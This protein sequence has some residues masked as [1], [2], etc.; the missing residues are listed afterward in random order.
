M[1]FLRKRPQPPATS[2]PQGGTG[3]PSTSHVAKRPR[4]APTQSLPNI[5]TLLRSIPPE[6][7]DDIPART[8]P[9]RQRMSIRESPQPFPIPVLNSSLSRELPVRGPVVRSIGGSGS[10]NGSGSGSG[11]GSGGGLRSFHSVPTLPISLQQKQRDAN[12]RRKDE[13]MYSLWSRF[14]NRRKHLL[15]LEESR[16]MCEKQLEDA[17]TKNSEL[18]EKL[19]ENG[20]PTFCCFLSEG[21]LLRKYNEQENKIVE[22]QTEIRLT[23]EHLDLVTTENSRLQ[24]DCDRNAQKSTSQTISLLTEWQKE[25]NGLPQV[26]KPH[27]LRKTEDEDE[28]VQDK[29]IAQE[30]KMIEDKRANED[31]K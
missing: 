14:E 21:E 3:P 20:E 29:S 9:S 17:R 18:K 19:K 10:G 22:C 6:D 7:L 4:I 15:Q 2:F 11:I 28:V 25:R 13:E 5:T 26:L 12:L 8:P 23:E 24:L 16:A 1:A 27:Q 31:K 30:K